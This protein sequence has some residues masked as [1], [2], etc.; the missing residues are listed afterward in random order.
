MSEIEVI[1]ELRG[2]IKEAKQAL[3]A[4]ERAEEG[5]ENFLAQQA[6]TADIHNAS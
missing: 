5:L 2:A 3:Q 1:R 4:L 6:A